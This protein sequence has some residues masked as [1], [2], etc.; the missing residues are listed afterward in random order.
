MD[1][2]YTEVKI[3]SIVLIMCVLFVDVDVSTFVLSITIDRAKTRSITV[4]F[5]NESQYYITQ[6]KTYFL[7]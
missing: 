7:L 1:I 3:H 2:Y 4:F 6:I 5:R